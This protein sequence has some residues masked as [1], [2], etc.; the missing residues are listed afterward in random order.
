MSKYADKYLKLADFGRELLYK[1]SLVDGLPHISKYAKEIIGA[2]RCSIFIYDAEKHELWT[3]LAD[4]VQRIIVDSDKGLVGETL[5]VKKVIL[6]NDAY[7]NEHFLPDIDA[8]TG[9]KTQNV[10]TAPIFNS[11]QNIQGV[12][13]LLN[14]DG[15]FDSEDTKFMKFFTHYISGFLELAILYEKSESI[16]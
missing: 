8:K 3:T 16:N 2:D 9:Y 7:S 11:N 4:K 10:I 6:E 13:Q 12:L 15:G 1:K 5:R 14:K